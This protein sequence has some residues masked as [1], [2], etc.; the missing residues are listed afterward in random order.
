MEIS[1]PYL[2]DELMAF[3]A[4]GVLSHSLGVL[5]HECYHDSFF[6]SANANR[7][8]GAWLFHYPLLGRF[9]LLKDIHLRHHRFFGTDRDPDIDHW[10]WQPGDSRHVLHIFKLLT[11]ISFVGNV[12]KTLRKSPVE[13]RGTD[14]NV[15]LEGGR[16]DFFGVLVTQ[17]GIVVLFTGLL[18]FER[19][20]FLWI[21]PIVTIG[22]T[23]EHLRVFAEHNGG[24]LRIFVAPSVV[25]LLV[26][27]RANFRLHALHHQA[28]S[29]P[30]FALGSKYSTVKARLGKSLE[31]SPSYFAE[32]RRIG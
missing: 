23:V 7:I 4:M 13:S 17:F 3:I 6:R 24:K 8:L 20:I 15:S 26:F 32:I 1:T 22:A 28:P 14:S 18:S 11:G 5:G 29:V 27:S 16:R 25:E 21:L 12:F 10:G 9:E 19:Y 31:E 30:W 2:V